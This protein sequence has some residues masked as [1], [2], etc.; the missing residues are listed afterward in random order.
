MISRSEAISREGFIGDNPVLNKKSA[1]RNTAARSLSGAG[2]GNA[3]EAA[4]L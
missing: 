4:A 2:P 1:G 3:F